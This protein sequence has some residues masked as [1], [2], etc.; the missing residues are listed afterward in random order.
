MPTSVIAAVAASAMST[1]IYVALGGTFV[2]SFA[3]MA[4]L[5]IEAVSSFVIGSA[6]R[7]ALGSGAEETASP[8]FT[9]HA[10]ARTH[11]VR[12]A[13]ANRQ[14]IYGRAMI[15]GPLV[16]AA[17][18]PDNSELHLVVAL[19]GHEIDAIE[20]VYFGDELST[21]SKFTGFVTTA[22]HLGAA[23]QVADADL[24]AANVGWTGA[25]RLQGVAYVYVKLTYDQDVFP[26]GI[27]NIKCIVRGK[28]LYDPRTAT[29]V[30]SQNMALAVRDYLAGSHGLSAGSSEIDDTAII[31]AANICDEAVSL[32]A[33]GTEARYTCNG[34]LDTGMTP[35]ACMESLLSA[36][37]AALTWPAGLWTLHVGAYESPTITLDEDDLAGPVQVRAR[38]PRQDLF[39]AIKG[40]YVDPD[41]YWQPGDFPPVTNSTY[42]TQDGAQIFRDIALPMTTSPATA[43]RLAQ[44]MVE[45]SRQGITVTAPFKLSAF[46]LATWD[47]VM[48]SL[49][50]LGWSSKVFKVTGWEFNP[51]G[52]VSLTLQEEA[53]ACY[54]WSATETITDP[55]PDTNLPDAFAIPTAPTSLTLASGTDELLV[56]GDGTIMSRIHATWQAP[57]DAFVRVCELQYKQSAASDWIAGPVTDSAFGFAYLNAVADAVNYDVRARFR[58]SVG[59]RSAWTTVTAHTVVGKTEPP[60]TVAG[61]TLAGNVLTWP[62]V[63]DIDLAGYRI[64]FQYGANT[65]W[66]TA[67]AIHA[68]LVTESPYTL[69]IVP[70]GQVTIMVRAV[71]TSGNESAASAYVITDF[72][73]TPVAN[74]VES[75]DYRA[76]VWPGDITGAT[77]SGGNIVA[78]QPDLFYK[79]DASNFYGADTA[80]FYNTNYAGLEWISTGWTPTLAAAGSAMTIA[81]TLTGEA[82][83]VQYRPTGP[84]LFYGADLDYFYGA[85]AEAFY[86][87]AGA[88]QTWPGSLVASNEEIQ[89][90]VAT[91]AGLTA[92]L[93]SAFVVSIDVPDKV[94]SLNG[95]AIGSGGSRLSGAVGEF[96][97]IQ[98]IQLT[99]QGGS[100][101]MKLEASDYN[102]AAGPLVDAKNS[103][104]TGVAATIDVFLQ[105]Y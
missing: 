6:L 75:R 105:G 26:R 16:F 55:A 51:T 92:G 31:A 18:S 32:A 49:S 12:S 11:V 63:A 52:T 80:A 62:G 85:D 87:A 69:L 89:F 35:R 39:N 56:G 95:V 17:C 38:V 65:E 70:P 21:D 100:T 19:A 57:T 102:N 71:D 73:D 88:W 42:A 44:M 9:A 30:W 4:I 76:L 96:N 24:V 45:K 98:N 10:E 36:G 99:L 14:T 40:T 67:N 68:G 66:G 61:L 54:T 94:L 1:S 28:K 13:I 37:G 53:A 59:V 3:T 29:T 47:N 25:H 7:G 34:V 27:P 50:Q 104:G 20:A 2:S 72:G 97:V 82:Q 48:L 93:L 84:S 33:G 79:V 22:V 83:A 60:A 64:R 41:K 91:S 81:W 23:D 77:I 43:Q 101:A 8:A 86:A 90:R 46:K 78:D 5:G 58:N 15:S 103:S 74:V